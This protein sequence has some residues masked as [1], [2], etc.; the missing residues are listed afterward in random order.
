MFTLTTGSVSELSVCLR[1]KIKTCKLTPP[2]ICDTLLQQVLYRCPRVDTLVAFVDY[3]LDGTEEGMCASWWENASDSELLH[4]AAWVLNHMVDWSS[5][6]SDIRDCVQHV[7]RLTGNVPLKPYFVTCAAA[8]D[9]CK[10][11]DLTAANADAKPS[12]D[13]L[14]HAAHTMQEKN[15]LMCLHKTH[16]KH[17]AAI[18]L[19]GELLRQNTLQSACILHTVAGMTH[20]INQTIKRSTLLSLFSNNQHGTRNPSYEHLATLMTTHLLRSE[21]NVTSLIAWLDS[22]ASNA[23]DATWHASYMTLPL[24]C[25]RSSESRKVIEVHNR[26]YAF[27]ANVKMDCLVVPNGSHTAE[28][29]VLEDDADERIRKLLFRFFDTVSTNTP[30]KAFPYSVFALD[31][32]LALHAPPFPCYSALFGENNLLGALSADVQCIACDADHAPIEFECRREEL[33]CLVQ[34]CGYV[35]MEWHKAVCRNSGLVQLMEPDTSNTDAWE[36]FTQP[37]DVH[38]C[39]TNGIY[40][41]HMKYADASTFDLTPHVAPSATMQVSTVS[42]MREYAHNDAYCVI[43][44]NHKESLALTSDELYGKSLAHVHN[45]LRQRF[46]TITL[47]KWSTI[48]NAEWHQE[49]TLFGL[50]VE[51]YP[52]RL[53]HGEY[54]DLMQPQCAPNIKL[55]FDQKARA[56]VIKSALCVSDKKT[57]MRDSELCE[58]WAHQSSPLAQVI[59][60]QLLGVTFEEAPHALQNLKLKLQDCLSPRLCETGLLMQSELVVPNIKFDQGRFPCPLLVACMLQTMRN[61]EASMRTDNMFEQLLMARRPVTDTNFY[62]MCN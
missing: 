22:F 54:S 13:L 57:Y 53:T 60:A 46:S 34:V 3:L 16:G 61:I 55:L 44:S 18:E 14:A 6:D 45:A 48:S 59:S 37:C 21:D 5:E 58:A 26:L 36:K 32:F 24:T 25:V 4:D 49:P 8:G 15:E 7:L 27:G 28:L 19:I 39:K 9:L 41:V 43:A 29:C 40:C 33:P 30:A 17:S 38:T 10:C 52:Q 31:S 50:N 11:V 51:P 23:L 62:E 47:C 56:T 12:A 42:L 20:K 35:D 1:R 2:S